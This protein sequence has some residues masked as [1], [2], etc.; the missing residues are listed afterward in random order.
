MKFK[1]IGALLLTLSIGGTLIGCG[2]S[3]NNS[4]DNAGTAQ[5]AKTQEKL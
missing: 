1:R 4:S 2:G 3:S 5:E